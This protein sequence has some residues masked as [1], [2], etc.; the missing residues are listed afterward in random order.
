MIYHSN[1]LEKLYVA[2]IRQILTSHKAAYATIMENE[3]IYTQSEIQRATDVFEFLKC[4]RYPLPE[5]AI[6]LLQDGNIFGL[7]DL[8]REGL[9]R[10]YDI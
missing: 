1:K 10:A 9:S 4:N 8:T 2:D 7:P 3:S 6:H 5:E